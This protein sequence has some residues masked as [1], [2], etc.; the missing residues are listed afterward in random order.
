MV[1]YV[2]IPLISGGSTHLLHWTEDLMSIV[3]SRPLHAVRAGLVWVIRRFP[4]GSIW[5][6]RYICLP[7][8]VA[9][10]TYVLTHSALSLPL[11][12]LWFM[13]GLTIWTLL[14]YVIHRFVFHYRPRTEVGRALL[15]RFHILHHD[16][17]H[18]QTQVCIPVVANTLF[19]TWLFS[20]MILL[21]GGWDASLIV[22]CG[23]ALMMVV[24]DLAHFS[25]HYGKA[26]NRVLK[27]L[28]KHHMLHHFSDH[29]SR[30]GVTSPFWDAVFHTRGAAERPVETRG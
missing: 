30:F 12:A 14:E 26:T 20:T 3:A 19:W 21:G 2:A 6:T 1:E 7:L 15:E 25:A 28:K 18:D 22:T 8:A 24:Y 9:A 10:C 16:D 23:I 29:H 13:L 11:R 4:K 5:Q 17:P 27:R